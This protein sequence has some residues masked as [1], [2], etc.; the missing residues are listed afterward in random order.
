MLKSARCSAEI[1]TQCQ[2]GAR[3]KYKLVQVTLNFRVENQPITNLH[4]KTD[5]FSLCAFVLINFQEVCYV[6][7]DYLPR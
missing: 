7:T 3:T 4:Y 5:D 6:L 2:L 1:A